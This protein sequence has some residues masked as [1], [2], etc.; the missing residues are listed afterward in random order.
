VIR[1]PAAW[2]F[3]LSACAASDAP[4]D[5]APA[6]HPA[7]ADDNLVV[8]PV[9]AW[10]R[11]LPALVTPAAS[12]AGL[13]G[14]DLP[15]GAW[16]QRRPPGVIDL[17][18]SHP[19]HLPATVRVEGDAATARS[20]SPW[21]HVAR[22]T[23]DA[24]GSVCAVTT[25][26][27]GLDHAWFSAEAP[28]PSRNAV[29]VYDHG[30][31]YWAAVADALADARRQVRWSTWWWESDFELVR[32]LAWRPPAQRG[33][34]TVLAR[35][36]DVDGLDVRVLVNRFWDEAPELLSL[37]N[38]DAEL[39]ARADAAGDDFEVM[40]QGN[41]TDVPLFESFAPPALP[42]VDFISRLRANPDLAPWLGPDPAQRPPPLAVSAASFH[43]KFLSVDGE[44]AF[45][46]GMNTK[47]VDWD[48]PDH[49][50][51]DPRRTPVDVART[52]FDA[53]AAR[54]DLAPSPPRRDWG[55]R[56]R[57]PIVADVDALFSRRWAAARADGAHW[58]E[59]STPL[60]DGAAGSEVD[61]GALAQLIVTLPGPTPER[62]LLDSHLKAI[63]AA[64]S[65]V[66]IEDQ[67][68]R[69]PLLLQ[70]LVDQMLIEP[71]LVTLVVTSEVDPLDPAAQH[72]WAADQTMRALFPDRYLAVAL[73][74][75]T[76]SVD[77]GIIFDDPWPVFEPISLHSKL[78][79][80]DDRYLSIG[81]CNF[82]NR[83]Y[84]Y[85]GEANVAVLDEALAAS[86]RASVFADLVGLRYADLLSGDPAADLEVVREVA[87]ANEALMSWWLA[88][89]SDL[90]VGEAQRRWDADR[91]SGFAYPLR[92]DGDFTFDVGP[93]AF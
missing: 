2:L 21:L 5:D 30:E 79:V 44:V 11:G 52:D 78:R 27:V 56:L 33:A 39:R 66:L 24:D 61:G 60:A 69:A 64:R 87:E 18:I 35:L 48:G 17:A 68:F 59:S 50:P 62:S 1:R 55:A 9:D 75:A 26:F 23:V 29:D 58:S 92:L 53:V 34:D 89:G 72:T 7:C 57:G 65:Y 63:R 14:V 31:P 88:N 82:N 12:S 25:V 81:S 93:D 36:D 86:T 20:G 91:P 42:P 43:Q 22:R 51:F 8:V 85:E 71:G 19:D 37:V 73:R 40:L 76:L 84:L 49:D 10:G 74:A 32:T 46:S 4:V 15:T 45:V 41:P 70:A 90:E 80:V 54:E 13:R 38:T 47:L 6:S 3:A 28:A 16:V 77:V 83:G 67:Y